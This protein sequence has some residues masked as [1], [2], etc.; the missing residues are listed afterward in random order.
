[1]MEHAA[2]LD[3][4]GI[5]DLTRWFV[6]KNAVLGKAMYFNT[7]SNSTSH[8]RLRI[9]GLFFGL[10]FNAGNNATGVILEH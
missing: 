10:Q 6:M 1:M 7:Q 2:A 3:P 5:Y 8:N 9:T 4:F